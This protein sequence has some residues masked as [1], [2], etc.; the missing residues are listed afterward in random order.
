MEVKEDQPKTSVKK[1]NYKPLL[2]KCPQCD[3]LTVVYE[4][5]CKRC[6]DPCCSWSAC[7]K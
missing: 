7:G 2:E 5:G 1:I 3:N 6:I 4:Q